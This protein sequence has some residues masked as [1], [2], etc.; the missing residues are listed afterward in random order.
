MC[1]GNSQALDMGAIFEKTLIVPRGTSASRSQQA[2][3]QQCRSRRHAQH[4]EEADLAVLQ[5]KSPL[6]GLAPGCRAQ[7]RQQPF[8]HQHQGERNNKAITHRQIARSCRPQRPGPPA[9]PVRIV[10]K[11]S[12]DGSMTITSERFRKLAR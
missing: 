5:L 11:N 12:D 1:S 3:K 10:R 8:D 6:E 2:H 4:A 7:K 9:P